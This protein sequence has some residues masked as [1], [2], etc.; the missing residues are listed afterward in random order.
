[1]KAIILT[2]GGFIATSVIA[3]WLAAGHSIAALWIG[4]RDPH[5]FVKRNRPP[6]GLA[7]RKWSIAAMVRQHDISVER[8]P[9]LSSRAETDIA[10]Q[11]LNADVLITALT[12]EIVPE[13]FLSRFSGRA[14][15]FH[16]ALLPHYRGPTPRKGM[17]LDGK[18]DLYGGVTLHCLSARVDRGDIIGVRKVPYDAGSGFVHW[19]ICLA[20]AAEEL[21]QTELQDYLNGSLRACPQSAESGSYRKVDWR[22]LT[23]SDKQSAAQ[24]KW[25]CGQLGASGWLRFRT[26]KRS[27]PVCRF[28][29]Q[30]GP[31]T[32][33]RASIGRFA[34]EFDAA[35]ARVRVARERSWTRFRRFLEFWITIVRTRRTAR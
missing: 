34:I 30:L 28:V 7:P 11:R 31:R 29:R 5:R 10:L 21:V 4:S 18:S 22:E 35:D 14:V 17:V 24:T 16:P 15:N 26:G 1:M 6:L 19:E 8:T 13:S 33:K 32:F 27:Y 3:A 20:R 25:L 23:L 2:P 12:L 9:N